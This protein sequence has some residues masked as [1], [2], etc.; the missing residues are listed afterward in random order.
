MIRNHDTATN[1]RSMIDPSVIRKTLD[2][3]ADLFIVFGLS[4]T[5]LVFN[6]VPFLSHSILRF[7]IGVILVLFLPGYTFVS[8]IYPGKKD[9]GALERAMLSVGLSIILVPFM[10]FF[11]NYT[12]V[13]VTGDSMTFA[14]LLLVLLCLIIGF[15]RRMAL[16]VEKRFKVD[17]YWPV[18]R[19]K[20]LILPASRK[21]GDVIVSFLLIYSILL[22]ASVII[23][24]IF[25]PYQAD[26][27]TEFYI[28]GPGG[29]M[30]NYPSSFTLGEHKP[31]TIGIVNQEGAT[32]D[33]D[34]IVT[35]NDGNLSHRIFTDHMTL[36]NNQT[37]EKTIN[38]APDWAGNNLDVK[39]LLYMNGSRV[40]PYRECNLWIN[41][42]KPSTNITMATNATTPPPATS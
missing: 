27:Y 7:A 10:G 32:K 17:F 2:T 18:P 11:L 13:G 36:A 24:I 16:P 42:T 25:M 19:I 6:H 15:A 29:K 30:S 35:L 3:F 20:K 14:T 12:T 28:L 22:L 37:L 40:K 41:V 23:Y 4:F 21:R 34:L 31:V 38:L 26:K 39:F 8:V 9:L 33:Y 1:K 5:T